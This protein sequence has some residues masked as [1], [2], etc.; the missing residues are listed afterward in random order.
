MNDANMHPFILAVMD[1]KAVKSARKEEPDLKYFGPK[2]RKV[3]G[4]RFLVAV[5]VELVST[6]LTT[7][8]YPQLTKHLDCFHSMHFTDQYEGAVVGVA[9]PTQKVLRFKFKIRAR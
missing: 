1:A 8:V 6:L 3:S 4:R 7:A 5:N 2:K 9:E